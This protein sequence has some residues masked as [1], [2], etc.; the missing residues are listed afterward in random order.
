MVFESFFFNFKLINFQL[1]ENTWI[2]SEPRDKIQYSLDKLNGSNNALHLT[3][4][5]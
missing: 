4:E 5:N 2:M 1:C 3:I